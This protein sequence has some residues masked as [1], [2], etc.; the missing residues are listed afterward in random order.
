MARNKNPNIVLPTETFEY[1]AEQAQEMIRCA[2]DPVYF[3]RTYCRITH[4]TKG[5]VPFDLYDY[6]VDII[7]T[8]HKNEEFIILNSSRQTG[9]SQTAGAYLLWFVCFNKHKHVHVVSNRNSGAM[10]IIDRI[11]FMYEYLPTWLK[12]GID[13]SN[14]NKHSLGFCNGSVIESEAT[15]EQSGRGKSISL[16]YCDEFAFVNPAIAEEFWT[17]ISPTLATGG[18]AIIS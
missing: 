11:Q 5:V 2:M 3:I 12:P 13:P 8:I 6:Q 10:E 15:T 1:T 17:S 18:R 4:P 16:M 7:N 9:K 14:W